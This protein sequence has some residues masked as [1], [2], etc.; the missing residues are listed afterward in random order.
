MANSQKDYDSIADE[1]YRLRE[2]KQNSL[3]EN[4]ECEGLKQRIKE[5]QKFMENQAAGIKE[6][7]ELLVRQLIDKVTV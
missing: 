6:Y 2:L 1:I 5:I 3:V 4:A 7:D